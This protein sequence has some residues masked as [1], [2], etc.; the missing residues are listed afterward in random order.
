[1]PEGAPRNDRSYI[2]VTRWPHGADRDECS[3]QLGRACGIE[4]FDAYA[5]CDYGAPAVVRR[6]SGSSIAVALSN[7]HSLGFEATSIA[8]AELPRR[9]PEDFI[10]RASPALGAPKPMFLLEFWGNREPIG[11]D[12]RRIRL[13]VRGRVQE[14]ISKSTGP[15]SSATIQVLNQ[16]PSNNVFSGD[17]DMLPARTKAYKMQQLLDIHLD[18]DSCLR[19]EARRFG[20]GDAAGPKTYTEVEKLDSLARMLGLGAPQ[21]L[22]DLEFNKRRCPMAVLTDLGAVATQNGDTHTAA[23]FSAYSAWAAALA[24]RGI[25]W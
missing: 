23:A 9:M 17:S 11:L 21:A 4:P 7:L 14:T 2:V 3:Q 13:L 6:A 10:K 22:I 18:D 25:L 16:Y 15:S 5:A 8:A 20:F 1:M 12:A 19:C 24:S